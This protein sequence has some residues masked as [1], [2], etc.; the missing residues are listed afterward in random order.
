M[1]T[2]QYRELC[3][4]FAGTTV[5]DLKRFREVPRASVLLPIVQAVEPERVAPMR[6]AS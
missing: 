5:S 2:D 1:T 3:R 4:A 6:H